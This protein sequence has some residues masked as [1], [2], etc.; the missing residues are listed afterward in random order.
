VWSQFLCY[1][2]LQSCL[3]VAT[4]VVIGPGFLGAW[5]PHWRKHCSFACRITSTTDSS[6]SSS[7]V[8]LWPQVP[9]HIIRLHTI[10]KHSLTHHHHHHYCSSSSSCTVTSLT[11]VL[12][13]HPEENHTT[14]FS[15]SNNQSKGPYTKGCKSTESNFPTFPNFIASCWAIHY[16]RLSSVPARILSVAS[17]QHPD[18]HT[19]SSKRPLLRLLVRCYNMT[20]L[21]ADL[22]SPYLTPPACSLNHRL[23]YSAWAS[24]TLENYASITPRAAGTL[25]MLLLL[26][27][28]LQRDCPSTQYRD[29]TKVS[30]D[31][32]PDHKIGCR[33][34]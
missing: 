14:K 33:P 13:I 9:R 5:H 3:C 28:C 7:S 19:H 25:L 4:C 2:C 27:F 21:I 31:V 10:N 11:W 34:V 1:L 20:S 18:V 32:G 26:M 30:V 16:S 8:S 12:D 23:V 29:Q 6:W 17:V 22:A 24:I 15:L